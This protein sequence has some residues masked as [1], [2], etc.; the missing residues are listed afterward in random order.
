MCL[1][2]GRARDSANSTR[3]AGAFPHGGQLGKDVTFLIREK[4][5]GIDYTKEYISNIAPAIKLAGDGKAT[6][7]PLA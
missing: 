2:A 3:S 7:V 5:L 1:L 6:G 4:K